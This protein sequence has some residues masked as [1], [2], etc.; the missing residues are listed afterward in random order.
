MPVHL[1]SKLHAPEGQTAAEM[2]FS[3]SLPPSLLHI[4][5]CLWRVAAFQVF[6][7]HFMEGLICELRE[8]GLVGSL[9]SGFGFYAARENYIEDRPVFADEGRGCMGDLGSVLR[10]FL[11]RETGAE[12]NCY[13]IKSIIVGP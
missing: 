1:G 10:A 2:V 6:Q 7:S 3:T 9:M 13:I 8:A 11:V 4:V 5:A 12:R